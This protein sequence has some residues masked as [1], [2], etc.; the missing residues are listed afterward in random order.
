[1]NLKEKLIFIKENGF[2][3]LFWIRIICCLGWVKQIQTLY[4]PGLSLCWSYR[5][6]SYKTQRITISLGR[7]DLSDKRERISQCA[8]RAG[9]PRVS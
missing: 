4:S 3:A 8:R 5:S 2:Q 7:T 6:S 9:L 1:M